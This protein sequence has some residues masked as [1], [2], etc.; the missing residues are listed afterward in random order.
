MDNVKDDSYYL[1]K[2]LKDISFVMEKTRGITLEELESNEVL[3]DSVLFRLIQISENSAKLT[4]AFKALHNGIPWQA[5]K[6][7]RNRIVHEYGD[8][9][10]DVV[11]QTITED[12]PAI[13]EILTQFV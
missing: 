1:R 13:Y 11:H 9:E 5:I 12:I 2:M 8:V 4:P 3:C 6:G 7:M 10:F